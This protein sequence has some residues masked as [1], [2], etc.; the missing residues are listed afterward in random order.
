MT[1]RQAAG[2]SVWLEPL[3][4]A[5]MQAAKWVAETFFPAVD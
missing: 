5:S 4:R 2:C 1:I 3:H